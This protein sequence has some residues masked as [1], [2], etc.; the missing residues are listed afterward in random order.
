MP[1]GR[2]VPEAGGRTPEGGRQGPEEEGGERSDSSSSDSWS[3]LCPST[4]SFL[5]HVEHPV[6]TNN[7]SL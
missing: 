6:S 3:S 5:A 4:A 1:G 2:Q 7:L